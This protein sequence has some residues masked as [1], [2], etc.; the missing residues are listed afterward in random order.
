MSNESERNYNHERAIH[1]RGPSSYWMH[2][3]QVVFGSL[4]LEA[5]DGFLDLG[6]GPGD[7]SIEASRIVGDSGI[8]Y[9]L[10]D[11][12]SMI[13]AL[14]KKATIRGL[15]N[16]KAIQADITEP[17][18]IESNCIDVCLI[19]TVLHTPVVSKHIRTVFD[20]IH[21]VLKPGGRLAVIECKKEEM[22]FG[23][24]KDMR[25]S[26]DDIDHSIRQCDFNKIGIIDLVY[27]YMVQFAVIKSI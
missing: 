16:L 25:L 8:V 5:G 19:A 7:Y 11:M 2:D 12:Q 6:C 17:L 20:E 10:D 18:P 21:R 23:P 9:A 24:P 27:N 22:P 15:V 13:E 26:P 4:A 3:P 1:K 14:K